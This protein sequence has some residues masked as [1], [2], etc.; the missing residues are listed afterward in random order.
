M[1]TIKRRE[2]PYKKHIRRI[3]GEMGHST[4]AQ[5]TQYMRKLY[6]DIS[7]TTVHRITARMYEDNELSL[8]PKAGDGSVRYDAKV[9]SHDHFLC[10]DCDRLKDIIIPSAHRLLLE[11]EL[12]NCLISGPLTV[13]GSCHDCMNNKEK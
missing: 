5:I 6:P 9:R 10:E 11:K 2:T 3:I 1:F 13:S 4:N 12:G 8:G 7:D